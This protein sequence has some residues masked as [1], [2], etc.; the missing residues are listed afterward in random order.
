MKKNVLAIVCLILGILSLI[1]CFINSILGL[2]IGIVSFIL[3]VIAFVKKNK[4]LYVSLGIII[5]IT[6][7]VL[8]AIFLGMS[9]SENNERQYL[10]G[11]RDDIV[12]SRDFLR[13]L[14]K[15][16]NK[17]NE[18]LL[19]EI[20]A[21]QAGVK[22]LIEKYKGKNPNILNESMVRTLERLEELLEL[23]VSVGLSPDEES[24][25]KFQKYS[26]LYFE[27]NNETV[28]ILIEK[29]NEYNAMDENLLTGLYT[30]SD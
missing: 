27:A 5:S 8:S 28:N 23:V 21:N 16:E 13:P 2:L 29:N 9:I 4:K 24:K 12:L 30:I 14:F 17:S 6:G 19:E 11:V 22:S 10:I 26:D 7:I 1:I 18:V 15:N 20:K 3:G 25:L